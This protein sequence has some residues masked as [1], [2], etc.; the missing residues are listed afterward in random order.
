MTGKPTA[1]YH[2]SQRNRQVSDQILGIIQESLSVLF[3]VHF[4]DE[5]GKLFDQQTLVNLSADFLFSCCHLIVRKPL[6]DSIRIGAINFH[7]APPDYPGSGAWERALLAGDREFGCTAHIMYQEVDAGPILR[8]VRFPIFD[9][10]D[11]ETLRQ[12]TSA[13]RLELVRLVIEDL[14]RNNWQPVPNG[15]SWSGKAMRQKEVDK[16]AQIFETDSESDVAKKLRAFAHSKKP[17]PFIEKAGA[18]FWYLKGA[19]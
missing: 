1:I 13:P 15:E 6:L 3:Q 5:D 10:D 18:R 2:G 8:V 12:R 19:S 4:G 16:W 7:P 9:E 14:K 11:A 17:G